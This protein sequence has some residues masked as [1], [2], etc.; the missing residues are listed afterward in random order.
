MSLDI[1]RFLIAAV[2]LAVVSGLAS[3]PAGA[4]TLSLAPDTTKVDIENIF[5][6]NV[7][8]GPDSVDLMGYHIKIDFDPEYLQLISCSEGALPADSGEETFFHW[9]KESSGDI[10]SINGAILGA[11]VKTPGDIISVELKA[12]KA[13]TTTM[14]ITYS[15]I[16]DEENMEIGHDT[17]GA[18]IIITPEVDTEEAS[19]GVL[20]SKY[21]RNR[22]ISTLA[23]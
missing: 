8:A 6:I 2:I 13:G 11:V 18:V 15:D 12:L 5:E 21:R 3:R 23:E 22:L 17:E 4:L 10:I 19:W 1:K 9:K 7:A 20:K 16:R 14:E